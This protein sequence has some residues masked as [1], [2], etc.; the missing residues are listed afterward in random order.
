MTYAN[1]I[2][3]AAKHGRIGIAT[4]ANGGKMVVSEAWGALRGTACVGEMTSVRWL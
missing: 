4:Y 2:K 1:L 3:A